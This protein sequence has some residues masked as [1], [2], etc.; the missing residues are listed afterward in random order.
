MRNR[1]LI[2]LFTILTTPSAHAAVRDQIDALI[3]I[4]GSVAVMM[5]VMIFITGVYGIYSWS[6]APLQNPMQSQILKIFTGS[7]LLSLAVFYSI[8]KRSTIDPGWSETRTPLA[9]DKNLLTIH[10]V[11]NTF[12]GQ[13]MPAE[14][15][16]AVFGMIYVFGFLFFIKGIVMLRDIGTQKHA[17]FG[18]AVLRIL[19]GVMVMNLD[20]V[21]CLFGNS[22]GLPYICL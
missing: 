7:A 19:G 5:G 6:K 10:N 9:L 21:S 8:I 1:Y 12:I 14:T 20:K 17:N 22:F 13:F 15:A 3:N 18:G 2:A 11:S 4:I 16:E